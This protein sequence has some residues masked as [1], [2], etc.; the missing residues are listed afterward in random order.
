MAEP[1]KEEEQVKVPSAFTCGAEVR[2]HEHD[3]DVVGC[4]YSCGLLL[5]QA[6]VYHLPFDF[7]LGKVNGVSPQPISCGACAGPLGKW[8]LPETSTSTS[9]S[10]SKTPAARPR[11]TAKAKAKKRGFSWPFRLPSFRRR[12]K[13]SNRV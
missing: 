1:S 11:A 8:G 12:R 4:C 5:C 3:G 2:D 10:E 9:K 6:H 13:P 7:R